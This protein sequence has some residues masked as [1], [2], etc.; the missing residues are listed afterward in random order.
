MLKEGTARV[1]L[2]SY[3]VQKAE[4]KYPWELI[5]LKMLKES[6][7]GIYLTEKTKERD[8]WKFF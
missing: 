4:K 6:L 5:P 7:Q 1:R 3:I 8:D 2:G